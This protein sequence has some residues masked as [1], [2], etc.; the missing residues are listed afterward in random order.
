VQAFT[1]E[2]LSLLNHI[3]DKLEK[4]KLM[5]FNRSKP[6]ST[7]VDV[8]DVEPLIGIHDE[9]KEGKEEERGGG[10]GGGGGGEYIKNHED[11]HESGEAY[12]IRYQYHGRFSNHVYHGKGTELFEDGSKFNGQVR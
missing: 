6:F 7:L 3:N 11:E 1:D 2:H 9:Y 4:L 5:I 12:E 8:D 10:G